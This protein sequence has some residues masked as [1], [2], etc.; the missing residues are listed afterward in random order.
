VENPVTGKLK[1]KNF[2][3]CAFGFYIRRLTEG[4]FRTKSTNQVQ[5]GWNS[6][7]GVIG[8]KSMVKIVIDL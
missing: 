6:N 7:P 3:R 1:K 8:E 4:T 2:F 5:K